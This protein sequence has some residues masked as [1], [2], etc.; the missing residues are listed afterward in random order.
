MSVR[1]HFDPDGTVQLTVDDVE[2]RCGSVAVALTALLRLAQERGADV[3]VETTDASGQ[4]TGLVV[5][6]D[7]HYFTPAD[8]GVRAEVVEVELPASVWPLPGSVAARPTLRRTPVEEPAKQSKRRG[9]APKATPPPPVELDLDPQPAADATVVIPAVPPTL[10]VVTPSAAGP[11][12][13]VTPASP[14]SPA[15]RRRA[16]PLL[17]AALV[18]VVVGAAGVAVASSGSEDDS[19]PDVVSTPASSTP[20]PVMTTKPP[21]PAPL[22]PMT[23]RVRTAGPGALKV[24]SR[25]TAVRVEISRKG[26]KLKAVWVRP[27]K[28]VRIKKLPARTVRWRA[29]A[30]G[31]LPSTGTIKITK[32]KAKKPAAS[33]ATSAPTF[34]APAPAPKV[35][36]VKPKPKPK[37]KPQKTK[38]VP[39][40]P[41]V[42]IDPDE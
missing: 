41:T 29:T 24:T 18:T 13:A 31:Y 19:E 33:A 15:K 21:T 34:R 38:D 23:V 20:A 37:P 39:S 2:V 14:L 12:E 5:T 32:P 27:G 22:A 30:R 10:R 26:K 25:T 6:T 35:P 28:S 36:K 3:E 17:V 1:A 8:P 7:G 9:R 42:P 4:V 40:G 16:K 11:T